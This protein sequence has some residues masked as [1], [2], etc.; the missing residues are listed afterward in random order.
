MTYFYCDFRDAKKQGVTGL[1]ASLLAQLSAKS[2][3]CHNILAAL[4]SDFN[5][6]LD[7]PD[8]DTFLGCFEK[9]LRAEGQPTIYVVIDAI[10]ECPNDSNVKSPRDK[11]LELMKK[12]VD[13]DLPNVRICAT[14]RSEADIHATLSCLISHTV[15]LHDAEGH[16]K[17]IADYIRSVV[18]STREMESWSDEDKNLVIRRLSEKADCM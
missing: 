6:G 4:H 16:K 2:D 18:Y 13:L 5:G 14:S 11:V 7:Q 12:L 10:D 8:N 15:S 17:D 1:L 3:A 9:M